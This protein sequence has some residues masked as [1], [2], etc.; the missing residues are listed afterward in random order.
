[1]GKTPMEVY[2]AFGQGLISGTD[3]W[4]EAVAKNVM[5]K[6]PVDEVKGLEAFA[7]LNES[8]MPMIIGNE[9]KQV[10]EAGNFV[11]T[12]V[13]MDIAMPSG[14]TVQLDMSEWY[15]I[16]DGK[17]QSIKIYYDAEEFRKEMA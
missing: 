3:S 15:E 11:I 2:Q 7:K 17:I 5:F 6:G 4:K 12:Q 16:K 13:I 9:M 10:L 8:F 14:K 1:M